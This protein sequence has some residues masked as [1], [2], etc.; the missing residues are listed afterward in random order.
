MGPSTGTLMKGRP[1]RDTVII[2]PGGIDPER[3]S[4]KG[5]GSSTEDGIYTFEGR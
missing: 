1:V 4:S 5:L 2:P 3:R